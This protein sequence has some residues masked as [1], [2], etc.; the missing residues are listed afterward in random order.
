MKYIITILSVLI[1]YT[2]FAQSGNSSGN[3]KCGFDIV[4]KWRLDNEPGYAEQ[5][6]KLQD[7]VRNFV[8]Q[9]PDGYSPKAVITVPVVFHIVL[10][11]A[12]HATFPD[13]RCTEQITTLNQDFAGLNT[14]SMEAFAT[15]LKANTNIQFCLATINPSN[16]P[17][18][19]IE[20]V[21]YTGPDWTA[22]DNGVKQTASGGLDSWDV[23]QYLNIWVCNL[24]SGLAGYG[25]LPTSLYSFYGL[26][27]DYEYTG[28]TG[29]SAP[30]NLGGTASHEIGHCFNMLHVWGDDE[31]GVPPNPFV[32]ASGTCCTAD[33]GM[34]DT[35]LQSV[36]TANAPTGV[37]TDACSPTSPGIMYMN[38]MDY[39]NDIAYANFTPEQAT[40][41]S[42]LFE[43]GQVLEPLA[44]SNKCGIPI[45]AD[46]VGNPVVVNVGGTVNFT[47]LSSG[48]PTAWNWTFS[49][50]T[51]V[52]STTQNPAIVY[53]T[54]GFY[55]VKL[56]ASK[57]GFADSITKVNYIRVVDPNAVMADF[58][59]NPTIVVAGNSVDF[60]DLSTNTPTSWQWNFWGGAPATSTVKNPQNIV[61]S[62]AGTYNVK[63]RA[64]NAQTNDTLTKV[65]Y[66]T[67]I[68]PQDV[69]N[70]QFT[71]D[72]W[73]IPVGSSINFTDL[74]TGV[75]DSAHWYFTG[76]NPTESTTLPDATNI[77][78]NTIG[79]YDVTL[80]IFGPYGND[81]LTKPLYI[82]VFDPLTVSTV[83]ADFQAS[84]S[85]LIVMGSTVSFEDLS[86]G[87][88]ETWQWT[89]QGGTPATS[90]VANP[91]DILYTQATIYDVC[92]I[93]SNSLDSD[94]LCKEDYIVVTT[95][96]WQD[97]DGFCD[98]VANIAPTEYPAI[99]MHLRPNNWGY[100]PGHNEKQYKFYAD[101]FINYTFST[102]SSIIV[103]VVKAYNAASA[104]KVRFTIWDMDSLGLPGIVLGYKDELIS[105]FTPLLYQPVTFNDPIP[106]N[107]KF[108][109]G[110]QLWYNVPVDTFV[111]YMAPNRGANGLNTL[112]LKKNLGS[113]WQ[114]PTQF[115]A[116]TMTVKTS[117]GI[118][119]V[120]C[121]VGNKEVDFSNELLVY[122]NPANNI[123]NVKIATIVPE[124]FECKIFDITGRLVP[125]K[126]ME[127]YD[128]HIEYNLNSLNEGIYLIQVKVNNQTITRKFTVIR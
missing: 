51:P 29:A 82:H 122:P 55:S 66:I 14:G 75:Y 110:F 117:L 18:N 11:S 13:L 94:T 111:V 28:L 128:A 70:A 63:L 116:D 80:I 49:G 114:T 77:Q 35:P 108:F 9:H 69:P 3:N 54:V 40:A 101:R 125:V 120:G 48:T 39:V 83:K 78:Y 10:S 123:L 84:T 46:F 2:A 21:D 87:D 105:S 100:F 62:T 96:I 53:N 74:S 43:P 19:G 103:P 127:V 56:V 106:V 89:F 50:G 79:D 25:T 45:V 121:L 34:N 38:F 99:F 104:N 6:A 22:G 115:F 17:T 4:H 27:V 12:E 113:V 71:V 59:G 64:A 124:S 8:A 37:V 119:I 33:D 92:L 57:T 73:S 102:I 90:T 107:G 109:V 118:Q 93:V 76:G 20:R 85:R 126:P 1:F 44:N 52:S 91:L 31:G 97:P 81:T 5:F 58:I 26:V 30:Y 36:A 72:F 7:Y 95:E 24:E 68:N 23:T 61:Y 60:T 86:E 98:T 15:N 32:C 41:M 47:D 112:Y 16:Q 88:I 42:A 65:N 67:V